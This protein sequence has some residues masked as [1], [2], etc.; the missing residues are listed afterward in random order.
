MQ[1]P[2]RPGLLT[3]CFHSRFL[4]PLRPGGCQCTSV[5]SWTGFE[6]HFPVVAEEVKCVHRKCWSA[7]LQPLELSRFVETNISLKPHPARTSGS[8]EVWLTFDAERL[9]RRLHL[10][11]APSD[12]IG[13]Q[14][15]RADAPHC[16]RKPNRMEGFGLY[17]SQRQDAGSE[18][19][20]NEK[21]LKERRNLGVKARG[22]RLDKPTPLPEP[23]RSSPL[24]IMSRSTETDSRSEAG[25]PALAAKANGLKILLK[26]AVGTSGASNHGC[27]GWRMVTSNLPQQR[28]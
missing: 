25:K 22:L 2:R 16:R 1:H 5:Q 17:A 4:R 20:K 10:T 24:V 27:S 19:I 21:P 23:L 14:E 6:R 12:R 15:H 9:F 18:E 28:S 11:R 26:G 8:R 7:H 3:A 13:E